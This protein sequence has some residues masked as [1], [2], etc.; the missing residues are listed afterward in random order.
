MRSGFPRFTRPIT[1]VKSGGVRDEF[2]DFSG[3]VRI[4]LTGDR[5][6][7][8]ARDKMNNN[9]NINERMTRFIVRDQ[10]DASRNPTAGDRIEEEDPPGHVRTYEVVGLETRS[11]NRLNLEVL[12]REVG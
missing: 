6:D 12:V 1:I 11:N 8:T 4:Y 3:E 9:I 7:F 5:Q 10:K 2:G